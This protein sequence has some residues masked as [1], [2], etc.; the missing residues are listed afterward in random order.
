[1]SGV[2]TGAYDDVPT[3]PALIPV[4]ESFASGGEAPIPPITKEMRLYHSKLCGR[5]DRTA[6]LEPPSPAHGEAA[7]AVAHDGKLNSCDF[8]IRHFVFFLIFSI[9]RF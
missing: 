9:L 2:R 1:M 5:P 8:K 6:Q 4:P 7:P 3:L